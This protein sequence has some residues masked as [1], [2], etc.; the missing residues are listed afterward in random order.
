M[1]TDELIS[2]ITTPIL[3]TSPENE[4]FWP[5]QSQ[6]LFDKLSGE[7]AI[8]AFTRAEGA[9]SRCEPAASGLRGERIFDWLDGQIPA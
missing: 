1:L 5:G 8:V 6:E 7:N 9:D 3:V 4:Q 2:R